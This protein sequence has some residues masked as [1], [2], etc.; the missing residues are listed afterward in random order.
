MPV[1][2]SQRETTKKYD[3]VPRLQLLLQ[4]FQPPEGE[5]RFKEDHTV[6]LEGRE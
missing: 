5:T 3:L 6:L 2:S 1:H 4:V